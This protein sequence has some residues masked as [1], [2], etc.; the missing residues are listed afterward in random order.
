M[1]S[2]AARDA[3]STVGDRVVKSH[4]L[5]AAEL[6]GQ[7]EQIDELD[8]GQRSQLCWQQLVKAATQDDFNVALDYAQEHELISAAVADQLRSRDSHTAAMPSWTHPV[9]G[10]EMIWIH[11]GVFYVGEELRR[12]R[13]AGFFLARHPVTN[14]QYAEFLADSG[15]QPPADHPDNHMY[16]AHWDGP[17]PPRGLLNHPVVCV[18]MLDALAYCRWSGLA[19][20]SEW[21]WEKAARGCDGRR[22]PWGDSEQPALFANVAH[23]GTMAVGSYS[24]TRSAYGCEDLVGNVSEWCWY[25]EDGNFG[26]VPKREAAITPGDTAAVRGS[27]FLRVQSRGMTAAHRR[28]LSAGRRNYWVGF[29]PAFFVAD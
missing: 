20:P 3:Q 27:C 29:R 25:G 7:L 8:D 2:P 6:F 17:Q 14:A 23:G 16:L 15:Y 10:L 12:A 24:Q 19:L 28:R 22:F 18:S 26:A 13:S 21:L 5:S 4:L 9:T 1:P 11:P